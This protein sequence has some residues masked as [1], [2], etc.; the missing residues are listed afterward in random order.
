MHDPV[1]RFD[2]RGY[3]P[4]RSG[5]PPP[6]LLLA[7]HL[8]RCYRREILRPEGTRDWL[9][10]LTLSGRAFFK[11]EGVHVDVKAGDVVVA[12]PNSYMHYAPVLPQGWDC[13][14]VHFNPRPE[15][16]EALSLP[17]VGKGL[18]R[19]RL[20][21][22]R[23]RGLVTEALRRCVAYVEGMDRMFAQDLAFAA[24]EEALFLLARAKAQDAK[25]P[26]LSL[27]ILAVV[28]ALHENLAGGHS[29]ASLARLARLSP[30]RLTHR[31]KRETGDSV[32]AYLL[33]LRLRRASQLLQ[34]GGKSVKE[35]AFETGFASPFYFSRQFSR[36]FRMSPAAYRAR[37]TQAPKPKK[38]RKA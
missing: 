16:L 20:E 24:L 18:G 6:G 37:V 15:W 14:W 35:I 32:I 17:R 33:K 19:M 31:F 11:Q 10:T 3:I 2:E 26:A 29:L 22:R 23:A 13:L 5:G 21:G 25:H 28:D 4:D 1:Q 27:P 36:H 9:L 38:S 7:G 34:A 12:E 30:T 8:T